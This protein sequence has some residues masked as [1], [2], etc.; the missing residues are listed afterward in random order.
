[1]N[2]RTGDDE[3]TVV[4]DTEDGRCPLA[5]LG[6]ALADMTASPT[7]FPRDTPTWEDWVLIVR[8]D[9]SV[10]SVSDAPW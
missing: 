7:M 2:P 3:P 8:P 9:G 6:R 5:H 1:M 10:G 4:F